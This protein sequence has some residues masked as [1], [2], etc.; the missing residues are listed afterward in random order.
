MA[1]LYTTPL[2]VTSQL[3]FCGLPLR[4]DTYRGCA[5][6]CAFCFARRRGG[7]TPGATV[8]PANPDQIRNILRRALSRDTSSS[9]I[10]SQ[11]LRRRVPIHF[12]GMSDPFQNAEVRY[13]V[14]RAALSLLTQYDYPTVI[15]T[16][17]TLAGTSPYLDLLRSMSAVVIQFSMST[18]NDD[19]ARKTEPRSFPPS[20]LLKVME[21]LAKCGINVTCRWQPYIPCV[22]ESPGEF[23]SRLASVGCAHIG[24]EHLKVPIEQNDRAWRVFSEMIG[25]DFTTLY[26]RADAVRDGRE[27]VLPA[28]AKQNILLAAAAQ[29]R[30]AGMTFGAADN[31]F[32][33]LSDTACCCSGADRF[34]GF[35]NFFKHQIA[36]AVRKCRGRQI[37]YDAISREWTPKGS[38][39]RFLNSKSRIGAKTA[40]KSTI[41][42]HIKRRW[43]EIDAP[44]SPSSFFGVVYV[45]SKR[46]MRVYDWAHRCTSPS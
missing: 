11:F 29:I 26:R 38:V 41:R 20:V 36:Y 33:Y 7:N 17:G 10:V 18:S 44:G 28:Q 12:G 19:I 25:Q 42:D 3:F 27:Y 34:P 13:C 32:Q 14:S 15:S 45:G 35:G 37:S 39:D 2:S 4:L 8:A 9:G 5:F 40:G 43:N 1:Q 6:H 16:R 22:S 23:V 24:I 30:A 21:K 46:G 31:E